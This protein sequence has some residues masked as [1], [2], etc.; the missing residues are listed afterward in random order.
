MGIISRIIG[1]I[2]RKNNWKLKKHKKL[3]SNHKLNNLLTFIEVA[4]SISFQE[5]SW[6][7]YLLTK[8]CNNDSMH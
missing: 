1:R 5:F 4:I 2:A 7:S 6:T 8:C 3:S